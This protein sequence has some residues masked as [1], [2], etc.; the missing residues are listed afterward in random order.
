[1]RT[2]IL[3][4]Q[5]FAGRTI[6]CLDNAQPLTLLRVFFDKII[7]ASKMIRVRSWTSKTAMALGGG[8]TANWAEGSVDSGGTALEGHEGQETSDEDKDAKKDT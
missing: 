3:G 7:L 2:D 4:L 1:L 6:L 8:P 5:V